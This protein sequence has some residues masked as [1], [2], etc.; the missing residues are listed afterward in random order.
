MNFQDEYKKK[1][2]TPEK[3]VMLIK[4]GDWV[5]YG[6]FG[7]PLTVLDKALAAR[8]HELRDIKIRT[9]FDPIMPAV[10][11]AD[12]EGQ[13]FTYNSFHLSGI[14]RKL[15]KQK[16]CYY[17]PM[18]YH[19][20]P[21]YFKKTLHSNV[22]MV[23]ASPMDKDGNFYLGPQVS[24]NKE[25]IESADKVILEVNQQ[26]PVCYG[27]YYETVHISDVDLIV[28]TSHPLVE[29]TPVA[30]TDID[31]QIAHHVMNELCDGAT[32][33]L[34]IGGIPNA[35][36]SMISKSDLKNLGIHTEM[37]TDSMVDMIQSGRVNGKAKN[38]NP[39]KHVFTFALGKQNCY[40]FVNRNSSCAVFPVSYVND[41]FVIAQHDN[42]MA[43]NGAIE[44][45]L[46]GQVSA[47]SSGMFQIS[48]TGGQVDFMMGSYRSKGGKGFI[49][50][51]S[52]YRKKDGTVVS[53]IRASFDPCTIITT[54]RTITN[55]VVT[56]YGIVQLK[57]KSTWERA[58]L[59]ISISHPDFQEVLIKEAEKMNIWRKS[60]KKV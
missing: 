39:E 42:F 11:E 3:A 49:C 8:K 50:L 36:G 35:I 59:L 18:L 22:A 31:R 28:E 60:Y 23:P 6:S 47:E 55:Y 44:V 15:M 17:V 29:M 1:L 19:E 20:L 53:R 40:D 4:S 24:H 27:G 43:I 52:T 58:E 45:D 32:I 30:P 34:G 51:P 5:E 48:G 9:D 14:E 54:P 7:S 2:T 12:P 10:V 13:T 25:M 26:M 38:I 41:P 46:Y 37:F 16:R 21:S 33:Q 57:G 56:E